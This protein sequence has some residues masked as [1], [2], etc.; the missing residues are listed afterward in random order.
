MTHQTYL[1]DLLAPRDPFDTTLTTSAEWDLLND[2]ASSH[3][4]R[5][6][7]AAEASQW[8]RQGLAHLRQGQYTPSLALLQQALQTYRSLGDHEHEAKVLLI[9]ANLY[10]RVADYLWATDYGRQCLRVAQAIQHTELTQRAL[11][12]LGNSYRHLRDHTK[13]LECMSKSL[14]L[15]KKTGDRHGEM[16]S[17]NNLA[18]V[19]RAKGLSRQAATLYEAAVLL[20][21]QLND[22]TVYLQIL[23]NLGNTYLAL[24]DYS[25]GIGCLDTFL[26][27]SGTSEQG[28]VDNRTLRRILQQLTNASLELGNYPKAIQ[29]LKRHLILAQKSGDTSS[30]AAIMADLKTVYR[31]TLQ[32]QQDAYNN[33]RPN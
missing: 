22:T 26:K 29:Y 23:Q 15:A 11:E 3:Q 12:H 1:A 14:G 27:L 17:L 9:L 28:S 31:T 8:L 19:Y 6:C 5:Q 30:Q 32:R 33:L 16:R 4:Q 7:M 20:A 25:Q 2:A 18:M 21:K 24:Q 10:Y 13:A